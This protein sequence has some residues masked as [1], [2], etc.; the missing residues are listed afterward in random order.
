MGWTKE[1]RE[2]VDRLEKKYKD[3]T[4]HAK[5]M[6]KAL[7]DVTSEAVKLRA[8]NT[9]L[10][11][12]LNKMNYRHDS[13]EQ[14]GRKEAM[15]GHAIPEKENEDAFKPIIDSANYILSKIDEDDPY[16]EF[17]NRR[18]TKDDIQRCHRVGNVRKANS[19]G[20]IRP[21]IAKFKDYRLRMAILLNK[22]KLEKNAN[23]KKQGRFLTEDLTPFRN[24]LLWYT[25]KTLP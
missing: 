17:A 8:D 5:N 23:F 18:I 6:T 12:E 3:L 25:K 10:C 1:E 21:I 22:K 11:A 9:F 7:K 24:K 20:K 14:Y 4:Q 13:L 2:R 19:N 16:S 15:R